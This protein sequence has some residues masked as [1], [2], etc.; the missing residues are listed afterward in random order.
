MVEFNESIISSIYKD[1]SIK[2]DF[3]KKNKKTIKHFLWDADNNNET[4]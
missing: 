2:I 3:L 1:F 4:C